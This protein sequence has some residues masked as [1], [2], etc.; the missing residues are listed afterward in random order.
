MDTVRINHPETHIFA[1]TPL[2]IERSRSKVSDLSLE[3]YWE[4]IREVVGRT[5]Q[6][7]D[8]WIHLLEGPSISTIEDLGDGVHLSDMINFPHSMYWPI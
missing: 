4:A 3:D 5:Q 6:Q 7:G 8:H 2:E 1:I